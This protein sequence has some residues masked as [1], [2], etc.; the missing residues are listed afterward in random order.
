M[1]P[2]QLK[3]QLEPLT[4]QY[5]VRRMVKLGTSTKTD[6]Q[7][8]QILDTLEKGDFSDRLMVLQS[9]YGSYDAS[10]VIRAL[11]DSS[12]GVRSLAMRLLPLVANDTELQTALNTVTFKQRR[13]LL[14]KLLKRHRRSCIDTFLAQLTNIDREQFGQ[15]LP[16]GS[17]EIVNRHVETVIDLYGV[18]EWQLLAR[19]HPEI[20]GNLLQKQA[21]AASDFNP[22]LTYQINAALPSLSQFYPEIALLICRAASRTIPLSR[23]S[24]QPLT[25]R[26]PQEVA[27]LILSS[28]SI[29][30]VS[31]NQ[32]AHK[33]EIHQLIE[34]LTKR[35]TTIYGQY[36]LPL[37]APSQREI[38]YNHFAGSWRNSEG[39]LTPAIVSSLPR[40]IREQEARYHLNLSA[41]AT[42]PSQRLPYAA[43]LPW[44]EARAILDPFIRNPDPELRAIAISILV[45]ATR[46]NRSYRGEILTIVKQRR[47]E[48][49]PIRGAMIAGLAALPPSM[50][51]EQD[52]EDLSQ[53]ISDALNAADLSYTTANALE[54]L[55][56]AILPF[57]PAWSAQQMAI[58]VQHRGQISFYNLGDRLSDADVLRIA[59]F[60]LPVFQSWE[61]R[62]RET[63]II[64]AARSLGRRL[65][66][67]DALVD[68]LERVINDTKN[69]WI[70]LSALS[71]IAENR[72]ER[73]K[74]LVPRLL[75]QDPSWITQYTVYNFVHRHRQDLITPFLGQRAYSGRFSTGKTRFVLPLNN[76][77]HRWTTIQQEIFAKTLC[78]VTQD[79][80]RDIPSVITVINQ[81]AALPAVQPTRL[82]ELA[83]HLNPKLAI[84]DTALRALSHLDAGQGMPTLIEAMGD[85][86]ARIAIYALRSTLL[87]MPADRAL[88]MLRAVPLEKVTVAKEVVRLLGEFS[89]DAAYQELLAWNQR[90]LHR[91]VR[92]AFL[93]ALWSHLERETTWSVLED[94]ATSNDAAIATVVGRIPA[95]KLSPIAQ[96]RL[97]EL[98]RTLLIHPDPLVRLDVLQRCYQL[99][100]QD[101]EQIILPKLLQAINSPLP[102]ESSAGS[103]ALFNTY[104]GRF[105]PVV[106]DAIKSI[107][108]N[109]RAL[110]TLV[111]VLVNALSWRRE[112]LLPIVRAVLEV[113]ES[114]PLTK[115]LQVELAIPAL[116]WQELA[117]FFQKLVASEQMH[118]EVLWTA[119]SGIVQVDRRND[120][121]ELIQ[122]EEILSASDDDRLRRIALA[123]LIS[124]SQTDGW[125][126]ERRERLYTFR[127]DP[128]PLVAE[129]AQFTLLPDV[130][131]DVSL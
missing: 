128:S 56:I 71:L 105:A 75:Q 91:D 74:A 83:S 66:V 3:K 30:N 41:L 58:L 108:G 28:D 69:S 33:L 115:C 20:A 15:L 61:T 11:T 129:K 14:R 19:R 57:Y 23:L 80:A 12:R 84:R 120:A 2:E 39:C 4:H 100:V 49:D 6:A 26:R 60:L 131:D 86:R 25:L 32:V 18:N 17:P 54:R 119:V 123:G 24:L 43:F 78:E 81:L 111:G 97:L 106:G 125:N 89:T 63:H 68:I 99:P 73:L 70:A 22:R 112:Q 37:L 62:E 126:S 38:I 44:D 21:N 65:R 130:D 85:D 5:R 67:F 76:G 103:N 31:F 110:Q 102:D 117:M 47:N 36:F 114:D 8:N 13:N 53:I 90:D 55:V 88:P 46:Y 7:V 104:S 51:H 16:Y 95:D 122:L 35:K 50:W 72:R 1:T 40:H 98:L 93:R 92:V 87:Q 116:P 48:Q 77:F 9:C 124:Q 27:D 113:M 82:I 42:R 34:L 59:P 127:N 79:T 29:P 45:S 52:L 121:N 10:R 96:R 109:R 64:S 94:A 101:P 107:L 118:P